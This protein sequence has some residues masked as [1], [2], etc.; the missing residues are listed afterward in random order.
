MRMKLRYQI[1]SLSAMTLLGYAEHWI[2]RYRYRLDKDQTRRC[3]LRAD[4]EQ[5]DNA[6]FYQ[7]M[8]VLH[9]GRFPELEEGT[10]CKE[11]S[12]VIFYMDFSGIFDRGS[13]AKALERQQKAMDM[14][15]VG[16]IRLNFGKEPR[17]Y[18]AFERS[19]SMSRHARLTFIDSNWASRVNT[20]IMLDMEIGRCQLSKLYSYKG[21]M[22]SSGT[23]IDGIGIEKPHRVIVVD[24]PRLT[25]EP[26]DVI[27]VEPIEEREGF[28]KYRRVE[29]KM[30]L[31]VTAFDGEGLVSK[32]YAK[33]LNQKYAGDAE[34]H[35][36]QIRMPFIKGMLHEVDYKFLL[37]S[38]GC[39]FITDIWGETHP[40]K[41]VDII[42][43]K[44]MFKGYGWLTDNK[45]SWQD[46]WKKFVKYNHAMYITNV[47]WAEPEQI[48][49]LNYQFLTTLSMTGEEFRPSDLPKGWDH[50]PA[51][52]PRHWLTKATEQRYYDLCCNEEYRLSVFTNERSPRA[53]VLK[54]NPLFLHEPAFTR[55][56]N[57]MAE[58]TLKNYAIGRLLAAGD[59]RFLSGDLLQFVEML[60]ENPVLKKRREKGY[61][62]V[63][64]GEHFGTTLFY[65]PGASCE[66]DGICTILRNPHISRNEEIRLQAYDPQ[67]EKDRMWDW[68]L[69]RLTSVVMVDARMLAAERLG[70]ADF[71]GDQVKTIS[72]PLINRCVQRNYTGGIENSANLPLLYIPAEEPVIRNALNWRERFQ[73]VR[74]T[75]SSRVGQISN[76]AFNRSVIA[77]SESADPD[78]RERCRQEVETLT[79]L[80]GLEI[81]AAKSG[82]KPDLEEYLRDERI[83]RSPFLTYK[84]LLE[85]KPHSKKKRKELL[86]NT[87][88]S[89]V[90]SN[91]ERLP[92]YAMELL[93]N[94]SRLKPV[95]A[96][97]EEL[98]RF[99]V[100]GWKKSLDPEKLSV[101][102]VLL[103]DYELCLARIYKCRLPIKN[104][105]REGD[106]SRVLFSRGQENRYD[107]E[108]LYAVFSAMDPGRVEDLRK[109]IIEQ[110]WHLMRRP[111]RQL[112][113]EEQLPDY[114]EWHDL[115]MDFRAGG[116]RVLGD[117]VCDIDDANHAEER[118]QLHRDTDSISFTYM[119]NAYEERP[120][121][122][123][124]Q[125]VVSEACRLLLDEL[126]ETDEEVKY[127]VAAGYR[128][129][130][131]D[132]LEDRIE[133]VA[134]EK[135]R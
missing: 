16:G 26:V 96:R 128:H 59:V 23:R 125:T 133:A 48:T 100:P 117:L 28:K 63:L 32:Q 13:S 95:P 52:D 37:P 45:M 1:H 35:S 10:I 75:F 11:L 130:I 33:K 22:F 51:E 43:T 6:L 41:D 19:N 58:K 131:W 106:I 67:K 94:T 42:L 114:E 123:S 88:W 73:T 54:K 18:V 64:T 72:D 79:I 25:T 101:V 31:T 65:A 70:G 90:N 121:A 85:D 62:S 78:E 113:L 53:R 38:S 20:R 4:E 89:E 99:A 74:D 3:I 66:S 81:D 118:K 86:R 5:E 91:V 71:D 46:Y 129:R 17:Y 57:D 111:E 93:E 27:T 50:S 24:N 120:Y 68:Y 76:A 14:F 92:L 84:D 21:L 39:E 47:G 82:V 127:V 56:L 112:F 15:R 110:D 105:K 97:D 124:Y 83:T 109:A 34:Y 104:R 98:F 126:V 103:K 115:F 12:D 107:T 9:D 7:T 134:V 69:H 29:K 77:Y 108:T 61:Y 102:T 36:F 119:M 40:V 2:D 55:Q 122:K 30:P 132:I 87:D 60:I 116:Y 8:C 49:E 44:S 80:T 135:K